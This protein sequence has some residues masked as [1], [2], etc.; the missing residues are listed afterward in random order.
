MTTVL[1]SM[2]KLLKGYIEDLGGSVEFAE[3][4]IIVGRFG[5]RAGTKHLYLHDGKL[6]AHV[7][8]CWMENVDACLEYSMLS[9]DTLR[10]LINRVEKKVY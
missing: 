2:T 8:N 4:V 6:Y 10:M 9:E 1:T 7:Y 3:S 5:D